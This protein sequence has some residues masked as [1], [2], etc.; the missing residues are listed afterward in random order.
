MESPAS[1]G[2]SEML[3]RLGPVTPFAP[4]TKA[5]VWQATHVLDVKRAK[6]F[7]G[8]PDTFGAGVSTMVAGVGVGNARATGVGV[9]WGAH[10]PRVTTSAPRATAAHRREAC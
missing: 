7:W 2:R 5:S 1:V 10:P 3:F 6:P 8:L 4:G 9:D